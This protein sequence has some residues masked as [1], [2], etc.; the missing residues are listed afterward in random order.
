MISPSLRPPS[1]RMP[2]NWTYSF[3]R[4]FYH[5]VGDTESSYSIDRIQELSVAI[6]RACESAG[7][8]VRKGRIFALGTLILVDIDLAAE[9]W[10]R[11]Q[12]FKSRGGGAINRRMCTKILRFIQSV[13]AQSVP[14]L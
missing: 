5:R 14:E 11:R 8:V 10:E 4:D 7:A 6:S 9:S 13:Q 2:A 3:Q 1:P 12:T